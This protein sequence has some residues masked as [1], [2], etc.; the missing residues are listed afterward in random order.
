MVSTHLC[1][2]RKE[3]EA[4][5]GVRSLEIDCIF[6]CYLH[7]ESQNQKGVWSPMSH[8]VQE[9]NDRRLLLVSTQ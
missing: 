8:Q 6:V 1:G 3:S 4:G 7:S 5:H 9:P 2:R